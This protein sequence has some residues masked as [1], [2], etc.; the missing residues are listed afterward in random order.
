MGCYCVGLRVSGTC[1][2]YITLITLILQRAGNRTTT[3]EAWDPAAAAM[4][5]F[6]INTAPLLSYPRRAHLQCPG[7]GHSIKFVSFTFFLAD[8]ALFWKLS[9]SMRLVK[10]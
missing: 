2:K 10:S 3:N 7:N 9:E 5:I 1:E 8:S 4:P 6:A